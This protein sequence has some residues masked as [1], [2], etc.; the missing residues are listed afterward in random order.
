[1]D[2]ICP[3][4]LRYTALNNADRRVLTREKKYIFSKYLVTF[5][6]WSEI[7]VLYLILK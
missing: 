6:N 1:M 2:V 5:E 3:H 4:L 7:I